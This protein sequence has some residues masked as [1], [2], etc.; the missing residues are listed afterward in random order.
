VG[1]SPAALLG[2]LTADEM[3]APVL[4]FLAFG[5]EHQLEPAQLLAGE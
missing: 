5:A 3:R 1:L 4:A 2:R